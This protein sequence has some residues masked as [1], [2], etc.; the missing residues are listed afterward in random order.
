MEILSRFTDS[1][2][3][4]K[5]LRRSFIGFFVIVLFFIPIDLTLISWKARGEAISE[6]QSQDLQMLK[7]QPLEPLSSYEEAFH[8]SGLFGLYT[9]ASNLPVFKSSIQELMK[10]LRLKGIVIIDQAEAIIEDAKT[11]KST[12]LKAGH[13]IG[14]L[15]VKEINDGAVVLSY[16][17]EEKEMRIQ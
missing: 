10:D 12:F 11:Q 7:T 6:L 2:L 1:N 16:Y 3:D 9:Y 17:G 14:E 15:T 4:L 13:Q 5:I 8:R